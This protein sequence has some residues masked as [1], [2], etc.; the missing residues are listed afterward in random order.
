MRDGPGI[1][2]RAFPSKAVQ[3]MDPYLLLDQWRKKLE[4]GEMKPSEHL[5]QVR[6]G[7]GRRSLKPASQPARLVIACT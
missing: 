1:V 5:G 3:M 2:Q 4:P 6:P 7:P